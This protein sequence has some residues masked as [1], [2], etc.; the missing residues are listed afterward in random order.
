M[1]LVQIIYPL[2]IL[3]QAC[4]SLL[5]VEVTESDRNMLQQALAGYEKTLGLDHLSALVTVDN[6]INLY[7]HQGKLKA[8]T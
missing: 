8:G 4:S 1:P 6:L 5:Y 7:L 2:R 3:G